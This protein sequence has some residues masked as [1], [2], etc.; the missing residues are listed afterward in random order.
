MGW[1]GGKGRVAGFVAV[2]RWLR[3]IGSRDCSR[4][5]ESSS[6]AVKND[7]V[8]TVSLHSFNVLFLAMTKN[9]YPDPSRIKQ[10]TGWCCT[11]HRLAGRKRSAAQLQGGVVLHSTINQGGVMLRSITKGLAR[12]CD[13]LFL[14]KSK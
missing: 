5:L 12:L 2:P 9:I 4:R 10:L 3:G 13:I 6:A 7:P 11:A 8:S 14:A 1:G